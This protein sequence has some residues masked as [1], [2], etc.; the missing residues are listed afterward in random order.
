VELAV[1]EESLTRAVISLHD[2]AVGAKVE[3]NMTSLLKA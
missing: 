2:I 1:S 3:T